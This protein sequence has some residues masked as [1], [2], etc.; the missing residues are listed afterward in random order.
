MEQRPDPDRTRV[1]GTGRPDRCRLSMCSY[2]L[3]RLQVTSLIF[4]EQM[5]S[6]TND[7]NSVP[8]RLI[9]PN[10]NVAS[11][12]RIQDL[13]GHRWQKFNLFQLIVGG[14]ITQSHKLSPKQCRRFLIL[15]LFPWLGRRS[16]QMSFSHR[17]NPIGQH[18]C[19]SSAGQ[20]LV[21]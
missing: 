12:L 16:T 7:V 2:L 10:N 8:P 6:E 1:L 17:F 19:I 4:F 13:A 18:S 5:L 21:H 9:I 11:P 14:F 3:P 20:K 15:S